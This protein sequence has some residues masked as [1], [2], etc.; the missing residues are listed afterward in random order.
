MWKSSVGV[1]SGK[2]V[3][4]AVGVGAAAVLVLTG[5]GQAAEK[6]AESAIESASGGDVQVDI[7]DQT[8]TFT[9]EEEGVRVQGGE[10][11]QLP[12]AFPADLPT[13]PNGQLMSAA[14]TPDGVS[15]VWTATGL[16][17]ASFDAY[18]ASVR[19]AGYDD[20]VSST[21]F[22]MGADGFSK[23]YVLMGKGQ[24]VSITAIIADEASQISMVITQ[25]P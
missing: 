5:C 21:E 7:G 6:A 11:T 19:S 10:G 25:E 13:P 8:M 3:R 16:D 18:V 9:D 1:E 20:E 12:A 23:S 24:A 22:D 17:V 2:Y 4:L 14:E 15:V